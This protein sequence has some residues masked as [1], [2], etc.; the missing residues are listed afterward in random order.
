M[1]FPRQ[2]RLSGS[3]QFGAVFAT[4]RVSRD[5]YFKV[6]G[7]PNELHYSRLGMA[8]SKR[9]SKRAVG[10]NR[11]IRLIRESF[12]AHQAQFADGASRDFVVL[13]SP[14]AATI[15]NARLYESLQAHWREQYRFAQQ[16]VGQSVDAGKATGN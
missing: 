13:P 3:G 2:R 8:V 10:R 1:K 5:R 15:S 9:A 7:R 6:L 11:L 14:A 4:P 12:R 16:A